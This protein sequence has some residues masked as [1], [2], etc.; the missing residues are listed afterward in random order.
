[1]SKGSKIHWTDDTV[2]PTMG[3]SGCELYRK[4]TETDIGVCRCY[5]AVLT[6]R[7]SSNIGFTPDFSIVKLFPGRMI[8]AA[9]RADLSGR[10]RPEKPW[11]DGLPRLIFVSDMSDALS[12]GPVIDN[13]LKPIGNGVSFEFLK[14]EILD[15]VNSEY[16]KRHIWQWLTK[17]P[18]RMLE[19][20][21]WL[22]SE[23]DI[24]WPDN[25]WA[26]TSV[27]TESN[28]SRINHLIEI[29]GA[30]T[31]RFISVE[32]QFGELS[33]SPYLKT[34]R[35][36]WVING[37]ESSQG[38][39]ALEFK[40]EWARQLSEECSQFK[41]PFF[42]KQLGSKITEAGKPYRTSTKHGEDWSQWPPELRIRQMP[43]GGI[44]IISFEP[45]QVIQPQTLLENPL[46]IPVTNEIWTLAHCK[47]WARNAKTHIRIA[48]GLMSQDGVPRSTIE[49]NEY[50]KSSSG[51][52][53]VGGLNAWATR[54]NLPSAIIKDRK[55]GGRFY[56]ASAELQA[57]FKQALLDE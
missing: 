39:P 35:I 22:L 37:G 4:A 10:R 19:F 26:G 24:S 54:K 43:I 3:C 25:L 16:G 56:F 53:I 28:L 38:Q 42:M 34:G 18:K 55:N 50:A 57:M 11:L 21:K 9:R 33:L 47:E 48:I 51:G 52:A 40:I 44:P 31:I 49:M 30:K 36:G 2:N 12:E 41:V 14:T 20:S 15:V 23:Y 13:E 8:K 46:Q 7:R 45:V 5:A 17:R 29:G 27:T 1:M 6:K 32:P